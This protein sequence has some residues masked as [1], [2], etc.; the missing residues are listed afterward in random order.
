MFMVVTG[1]VVRRRQFAGGLLHVLRYTPL[2]AQIAV[3]GIAPLGE[4]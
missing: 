1:E 4:E 3:A 2:T